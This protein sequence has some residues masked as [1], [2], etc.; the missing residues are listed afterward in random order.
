MGVAVGISSLSSIVHEIS[1]F[2]RFPKGD[3]YHPPPPGAVWNYPNILRTGYGINMLFT[4]KR[5]KMIR[6][7]LY[8]SDFVNSVRKKNGG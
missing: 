2:V 4:A 1:K 8:G 7:Q 5:V 3:G 6:L